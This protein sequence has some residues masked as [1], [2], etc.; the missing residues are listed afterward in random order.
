MKNKMKDLLNDDKVLKKIEAI[1]LYVIAFGC[2]GIA[3]YGIIVVV[4]S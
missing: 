4:N 2:L 3:I 1:A